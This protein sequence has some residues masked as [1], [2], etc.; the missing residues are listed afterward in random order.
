M[1]VTLDDIS[2]REIVAALETVGKALSDI[3]EP[4]FHKE[5]VLGV[6]QDCKAEAGKP[7][8]NVTRLKGA[9]ITVATSIQSV[10]ALKPA[11]ETLKGALA[12]VDKI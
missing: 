12:L 10:A 2:K 7:M 3:M 9:L 4:P 11:Y 8:P 1:T 6:V 5:E